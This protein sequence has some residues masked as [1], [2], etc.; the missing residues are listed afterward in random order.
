MVCMKWALL[1]KSLCRKPQAS[2]MSSASKPRYRITSWK[3]YS[4]A[5]K[6]H[7]SLSIWADKT[8]HGLLLPAANAGEAR[9]SLLLLFSLFDP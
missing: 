7:G 1:H 8:W 6:A 5:L 2:G 3:Q 9:G 4:A